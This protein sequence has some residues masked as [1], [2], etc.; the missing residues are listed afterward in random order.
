MGNMLFQ[1]GVE[2]MFG[3]IILNMLQAFTKTVESCVCIFT[4]TQILAKQ[5]NILQRRHEASNSGRDAQNKEAKSGSLGLQLRKD[6]S[7]GVTEFYIII[8]IF[9]EVCDEHQPQT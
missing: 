7:E 9:H 4:N 8:L 6:G 3:V 2:D 5:C 1:N